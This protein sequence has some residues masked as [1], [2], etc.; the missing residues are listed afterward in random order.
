MF[1]RKFEPGDQ[2]RIK[3]KV[4]TWGGKTGTVKQSGV[5]LGHKVVAVMFGDARQPIV[6]A[7]EELELI[8]AQ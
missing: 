8:S 4:P 5:Q 1:E 3:R 6:F 2:V 7:P